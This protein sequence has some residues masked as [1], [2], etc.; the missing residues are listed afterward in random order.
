MFPNS[1]GMSYGFKEEGY[2]SFV[3]F[4][5][6]RCE[7]VIIPFA[8]TLRLDPKHDARG[9]SAAHSVRQFKV[10][11]IPFGLGAQAPTMDVDAADFGPGMIE[12]IRTLCDACPAVSVR[13]EFTNAL[14]DKYGSTENVHVTGCPSFFSR[15]EVF[16][17]LKTKL[18]RE[19][20]VERAAFSGS[21]HHE[22]DPRK[23]LNNSIE[24]GMH[25]IEPVNAHL[26]RY[27]VEVLSGN[28]NAKVP[29]FL[30]TLL[31]SPDWNRKRLAD[32]IVSRYHL[33]RDLDSWIAFNREALDGVI[34]TRF[35]VSMAGL[36][37]AIRPVWITHDSR[38]VELC[39][40]L[41]LPSVNVAESLEK[42]YRAILEEADY[43]AM[44]SNLESNFEDFNTFLDAAGLPRIASP[45]L[46]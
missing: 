27:Y 17:E 20:P 30:A 44:Y 43:S 25:L 42:P 19:E 5:N 11:V 29:Y 31:E 7:A 2:K 1:V 8:N 35:H 22:K 14:F 23:Q 6:E 13:G 28:E 37:S 46:E 39:E 41:S 32:Y 36:L 24:Q 38:T 21:L 3:D 26:H 9:K 34:G 16:A 40:R 18:D 12:F 4:V 45:A 15:P 10:P 33:F